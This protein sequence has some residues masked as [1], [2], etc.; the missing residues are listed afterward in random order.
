MTPF[1]SVIIPL[2]NREKT[3]ARAINSILNQTFKD[4]EIIVVD[5][6]SKDTSATIVYELQQQN[7]QIRY[8]RNSTN[9]ERCISRNIGI[10][11]ANGKYISF[12]DSDDYHLPNHLE[13]L[14]KFISEKS[15][16][17]SFF[18]TSAYNEDINGNRSERVCPIFPDNNK[19]WFSYFLNYTVNPQRWVVEKEL[20]LSIL[21]DP[22]VTIC[23]DLDFSLRV[24]KSG[25]SMY[26]LPEFTTVYV[27]SLDSFT[28][29]DSQKWE[30][31][32]FYLKRIFNKIELKNL[33]PKRDK[34]RLVSMCYYQLAYKNFYLGKRRLTVMFSL[35]ALLIYPKG[36]KTNSSKDAF[37][38]LLTALF[39]KM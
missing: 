25:A 17:K 14:Y 12:L 36:Y 39:R 30:K 27:A 24:V 7:T 20:A 3:I 4:F 32:L 35:K 1:F 26:Q 11:H 31:E 8:I 29:G 18:F 22:N 21:F 15:F 28:H 6:C 5:D 34:K 37:I 23:E 10:Q 13:K 38:M 16:S 19:L 9:Q 33:L 2:Y